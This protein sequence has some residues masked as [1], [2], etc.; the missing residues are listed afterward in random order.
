ME[1]MRKAPSAL[2]RQVREC[3]EIRKA[4]KKKITLLNR[5][6]MYNRCLLP[7]LAVT[8]NDQIVKSKEDIE[9]RKDDLKRMAEDQIRKSEPKQK[10]KKLWNN[11]YPPEETP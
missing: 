1:M 10:K 8:R 4:S 7:E 3:I 6:D 5:K 11:I 2:E 9:A